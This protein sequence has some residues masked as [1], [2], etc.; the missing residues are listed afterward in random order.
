M[1]YWFMPRVAYRFTVLAGR[2]LGE[3]RPRVEVHA[4][5]GLPHH[6]ALLWLNYGVFN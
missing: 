3:R 5:Y 6:E 2:Y 4:V 1:M